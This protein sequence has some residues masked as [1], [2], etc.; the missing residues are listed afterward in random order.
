M[1]SDYRNQ[2][3][4]AVDAIRITS[5]TSYTWFGQRSQP[6]NASS[7][8]RLSEDAAAACMT[9]ALQHQLY[10]DFYTQGRAMPVTDLA[11]G[12]NPGETAEFVRALSQANRG[13]GYWDEGWQVKTLHA[14]ETATVTKSGLTVLAE[15][16]ALHPRPLEPRQAVA[17]HFP[18]EESSI[19]PGYYVATGA[20]PFLEEKPDLIRLY[21]NLDPADALWLMGQLT[22]ALS[23]EQV[24]FRFK[25]LKD[26]QA[27][28]RADAAVLYCQRRDADAIRHIIG[29][30]YQ[31]LPKGT[32]A[33]VPALTLALMPG[34]GFAEDP[35]GM[36][37]F[38]LHRCSLIAE[39][40]VSAH[41]QRVKSIRARFDAVE[42]RFLEAGILLDR[43]YQNPQSAEPGIALGFSHEPTHRSL[44]PNVLHREEHPL[45]LAAK[46]GDALCRDAFWYRDA[47]TWA[48]VVSDPNNESETSAASECRTLGSDFYAGTGGIGLFL[49]QLHALAPSE[50]FRRTA[51]GAVR[52]AL[53]STNATEPYLRFG[54]YTGK[55]GVAL[56]ALRVAH[57]L[58]N[59]EIEYSARA[60]A[61]RISKG[62]THLSRLEP[63]LLSGKAGIIISLLLLAK[64]L[65]QEKAIE[66]AASLGDRLLRDAQKSKSGI[67]WPSTSVR[68]RQNL[69]G[70]SHGT[71]GIALAL[72]ELSTEVSE[73]RFAAAAEEAF[74]YERQHFDREAGNWRDFRPPD[75]ARRR[76]FAS[77]WCNGAPGIALSRMRAWQITRNI[78]LR[79]EAELA[80][81][82]TRAIVV[83]ALRARDTAFCLCHGLAGNADILL[84]AENRIEGIDQGRYWIEVAARAEIPPATPGLM[85]GQAGIGYFLLRV[86]NP[87]AVPTTLL[88]TPG[89]IKT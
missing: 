73:E 36:Q 42:S 29:H 35:G 38:G 1:R 66:S 57:L 84:E 55:C 6:L 22:D 43:P 58:E 53:L 32:K 19:S 48:G 52:H 45:S 23:E 40:L 87:T 77:A 34:L 63:D 72:L 51:L 70:F 47:C 26:P 30:L 61:G 83:D 81:R 82:T 56:A 86:N 88:I 50:K 79:E 11:G 78:L 71:A 41:R 24:A 85:V 54:L 27:Y 69:T 18:N 4:E 10:S 64:E 65:G 75:A 46:I 5:A 31:E 37:S 44:N 2:I 7:R 16:E 28:R 21:W 15:F 60:M 39:A 20:R 3:E 49:A 8:A 59:V 25:T 17:V 68:R 62:L 76:V 74:F 12:T 14:G 67:S 13:T 9:V 89:W 80:L 33:R